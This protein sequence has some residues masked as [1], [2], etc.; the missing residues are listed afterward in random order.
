M[1]KRRLM[2]GLV[3]VVA[4]AGI[5]LLSVFDVFDHFF[6]R[7]P[8]LNSAI[9]AHGDTDWHRDTAEEFLFGTDMAGNNTAANHAPDSWTKAHIH[10]GLTNTNHFYY[11]SDLVTPGDD[12]NATNGIDRN[13]LFFYA[14][15]GLPT[16]WDTLGNSAIQGNMNLGDG[17][18]G[19][20]RYFWQ[21]S[22][23]TFAHGPRN[24]TSST[25]VYACPEDFDGSS[26]S[27]AMRNVYERWGP[28]LGDDLRLA[29]GV[30]TDAWCHEGN[31]NR[32]WDNYNNNGLDVADSF[33]EGL[34]TGT[35]A[36]P[37]CITTGG[38]FTT[39]TP[40]YDQTF[41]NQQNNGG[42]YLHI[43][44]LSNFQTN[45][46]PWI[47]KEPP[48][49]LPIFELI[50]IPLP[51]P[52][53]D[54]KFLDKD[55]W[56]IST[57]TVAERGP[58]M[59]VNAISGAMYVRGERKLDLKVEDRTEQDYIKLAMEH[60]RQQGWSEELTTQPHGMHFV[61]DTWPREGKS[62]K[63]SRIQKNV[64]V[65]IRRMLNLQGLNVPVFG[66]GGVIFM[67]MNNDGSLL[68]AYKV[69]RK[70]EA[71]KE[72]ARVKPYKIA[73]EEALK[74]LGDVEG[75]VLA[76]WTWGYKEQAGNVEQ[77]ELRMIYRFDFR[78]KTPEQVLKNP[79]RMIE[80]DGFM[81]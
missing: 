17:P 43:Q 61:I 9:S 75:Y 15:H 35:G 62:A 59:R 1:N 37:L 7:N 53:L 79:P 63:V 49:L 24:C 71:V 51:D 19:V 56:L 52:W 69:W 39:T 77:K 33:I 3:V 31:V 11:D 64:T 18:S 22:C 4:I 13:M 42:A 27:D 16:L 81:K 2:Y 76:D 23:E 5:A 40:L 29:C 67:Q 38:L 65:K 8:P 6:V 46:P 45:A 68:N 72:Q 10:D 73:E 58:K 28:V 25:L 34:N 80:V 41:T 78:P 26:D 14:G 48:E 36:V 74:M 12:D 20:L 30:S 55:G 54:I 60:V 44:Y 50:P 57:E 32:I 21:C 47:I 70:I 66:A